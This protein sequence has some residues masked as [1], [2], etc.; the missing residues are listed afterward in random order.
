M[1]T[2]MASQTGF[3][4]GDGEAGLGC[5]QSACQRR[6][7]IAVQQSPIRPLG[8]QNRLQTF[9]HLGGLCAVRSRA[10][11]QIVVRPRNRQLFEEN[12]TER[13][14]VMLSRMHDGVVPLRGVRPSAQRLA[15]YGQ[16]DE[17]RTG[18]YNRTNRISGRSDRRKRSGSGRK[19]IRCR[20]V[21]T[22]NRW[23]APTTFSP[24]AR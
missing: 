13:R 23:A 16:F 9:E 14:I 21:A 18:A 22:P 11:L 10:G 17:L 12:G 5:H 4:M 6:I 2:A 19:R 1:A 3:D 24:N 7:G 8:V 20:M 15:D